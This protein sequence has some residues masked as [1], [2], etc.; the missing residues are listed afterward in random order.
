M[1]TLNHKAKVRL[2][3]P[4]RLAAG[5]T[6]TIEG[7]QTHYLS[8]VMRLG[9]GNR[10]KVFNGDDGEW[11][12]EINGQKRG[13]VSLR[14]EEQIRKRAAEHG[15]VLAFAPIKKDGMDFIAIKAT[16]LGAER[17]A[18]V[19]TDHTAVGRVNEDRLRANAIEAAEQCGRLSVPMIDSVLPLAAFLETWPTTSRLYVL[20]PN[21]VDSIYDVF[22]E[23]SGSSE[24]NTRQPGFLIGPEGGFSTAEERMFDTIECVR[25]VKMGQRILRA[26]SAALAVLACWQAIA[27]DW[28]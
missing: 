9:V 6:V 25:R 4:S 3:V 20:S 11:V 24:R 17:L 22:S 7:T 2:H 28:R 15:P 27:G 1:S 26:E 12:A 10:I 13:S 14:I 18:P 16:E 19:T 23:M 5:Q 21:A 8:H